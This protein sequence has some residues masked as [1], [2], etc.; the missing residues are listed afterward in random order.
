LSVYH[1]IDIALDTF[2]YNG[3]TTTCEALWMGVPVVTLAGDRFVAR[4]AA[5]I[6][7]RCDHPGWVASTPED[8]VGKAKSLSSDPLRLAGI[9]LS[10]RTDFQQSPLHDP[11]RLAGEMH[12]FL[13]GLFPANT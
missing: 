6:V 2:P 10:L 9:R 4:E 11:S 3:I 12:R 8:Y 5:G 7:T 13:S 1:G